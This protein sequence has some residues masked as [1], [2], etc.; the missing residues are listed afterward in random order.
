MSNV[1]WEVLQEFWRNNSS[2]IE[3]DELEEAV[4]SCFVVDDSRIASLEWLDKTNWVIEKKNWPFSVHGL[5]RADI[6]KKYIEHLELALAKTEAASPR[7]VGT[8]FKPQVKRP[9]LT[10]IV[11]KKTP[12]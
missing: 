3:W 7:G 11:N 1:D 2:S 10:L 9:K 8:T 6:M 4:K 12:D 5:H